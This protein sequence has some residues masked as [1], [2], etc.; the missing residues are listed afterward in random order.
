[1][2]MVNGDFCRNVFDKLL[3]SQEHISFALDRN[4]YRDFFV[5]KTL[6][7][8]KKGNYQ[9]MS[10]YSELISK[11]RNKCFDM[12]Y[13][14]LVAFFSTLDAI[15]GMNNIFYINPS[16]DFTEAFLVTFNNAL[17]KA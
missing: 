1:M 9:E 17:R 5:L 7:V 3:R 8:M 2:T 10:E 4:V 16:A 12:G 13:H 14:E 6:S 15:T 11:F